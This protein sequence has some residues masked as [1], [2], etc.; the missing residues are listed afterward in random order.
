MIVPYII[1]FG[2]DVNN[3]KFIQFIRMGQRKI[4]GRL[5]AHGMAYNYRVFD[6]MFLYEIKNII[7]EDCVIKF[8]AVWRL[9]VIALVNNPN[10]IVFTQHLCLWQPVIRRSHQ[11]M[12][13]NQG[14][15]LSVFAIE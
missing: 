8:I 9:A 13:D 10:A 14:L 12:Q 7:T 11:P 3:N 5:A 15:A 4:H 1:G 2:G 6:S